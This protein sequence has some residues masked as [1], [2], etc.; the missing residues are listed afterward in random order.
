MWTYR[1]ALDSDAPQ[2][3]MPTDSTTLAFPSESRKRRPGYR[4][5][6]RSE[7]KLVELKTQFSAA[8]GCH[9]CDTV[10]PKGVCATKDHRDPEVEQNFEENYALWRNFFH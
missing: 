10:T 8:D 2:L 5:C 4:C 1:D 6:E 7:L 3:Y 9:W